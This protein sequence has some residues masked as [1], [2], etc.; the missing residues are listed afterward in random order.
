MNSTLKGAGALGLFSGFNLVAFIMVFLLVEETKARSLED[1]DLVFAVPK[2]RFVKFQVDEYLPWFFKFYFSWKRPRPNKPS[3]YSD[4]IWGD[5]SGP[6]WD[7]C[8]PVSKDG[9]EVAPG[10]TVMAGDGNAGLAEAPRRLDV[11]DE[12]ADRGSLSSGR[13]SHA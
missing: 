12:D 1:L 13:S 3:L 9:E 10:K 11:L 6:E 2:R 7:L 8:P 4:K 5:H